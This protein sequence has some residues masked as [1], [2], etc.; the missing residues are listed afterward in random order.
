MTLPRLLLLT[1]RSQLPPGVTLIG[2]VEKCIDAG[3][4]YVVLRELDLPPSVR[5]ELAE[6]MT[7]IGATVIAARTL[8]VGAAGVHQSSTAQGMVRHLTG[9]SCHSRADVERAASDRAA[10]TTLGPYAES[11]SKPGYGPPIDPTTYANL[12]IP[13]F[14]LGGV[15]PANARQA[16]DAGAYGVAVMGAVM[17]S[18]DPQAV[19]RSLLEAVT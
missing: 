16:I 11:R 4:T 15:T 8:V 10:Y 3:V 14:A 2:H 9:R 12:P 18:P 6:A 19:V 7:A 13:T 17:R 5:S 1:D